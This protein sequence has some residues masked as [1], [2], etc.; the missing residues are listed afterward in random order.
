MTE[1]KEVGP[2]GDLP[3][4]KIVEAARMVKHGNVVLIGR[5]PDSRGCRCFRGI[6]RFR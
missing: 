3:A 1:Y 2:A 5:R 4:D 6:H